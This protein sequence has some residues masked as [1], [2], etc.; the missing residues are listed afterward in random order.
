MRA[1]RALSAL[2]AC[3]LSVT[4]ASN[5]S[6][7]SNATS[8]PVAVCLSNLAVPDYL[9]LLSKDKYEGDDNRNYTVALDVGRNSGTAGV[10]GTSR[11]VLDVKNP[12]TRLMFNVRYT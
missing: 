5:V 12:L 4:T 8:I 11:Q 10:Q 1:S 3:I 9:G 6:C 2:V 7:F